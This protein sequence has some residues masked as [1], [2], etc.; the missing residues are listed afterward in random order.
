MIAQRYGNGPSNPYPDAADTRDRVE[1]CL[2]EPGAFVAKYERQ[3]S[4]LGTP[5]PQQPQREQREK[6]T[7]ENTRSRPQVA[8][9][10]Q[11][12]ISALE[13]LD[14][15]ADVSKPVNMDLLME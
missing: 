12:L 4:A 1:S 7:K 2:S 3:P 10:S 9:P 14:D 6:G 8:T 15:F 5:N 13:G 11:W